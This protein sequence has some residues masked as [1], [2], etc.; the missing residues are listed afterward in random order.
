MARYLRAA[1]TSRTAAPP[2]AISALCAR[3]RTAAP[4]Q[5]IV[6]GSGRYMRPD[7]ARS[8]GRAPI[9]KAG[10]ARM[11][12]RTLCPPHTSLSARRRLEASPV[13]T[14]SP[15]LPAAS[16]VCARQPSGLTAPRSRDA[17]RW[18]SDGWTVGE[19]FAGLRWRGA[20][21]T[22]ARMRPNGA[23]EVPTPTLRAVYR[24]APPGRCATGRHRRRPGPVEPRLI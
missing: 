17:A 6:T 12:A 19:T 16:R 1:A 5:A 11:T 21:P 22:G 15:G 7:R 9:E 18:P 10:R 13:G 14:L 20:S 8:G 4:A 3:L 23:G 2:E 24:L